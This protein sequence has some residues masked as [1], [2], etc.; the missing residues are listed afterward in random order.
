MRVED[1]IT[2]G[3]P[4]HPSLTIVNK[5]TASSSCWVANRTCPS[6]NDNATSVSYL[7]IQLTRSLGVGDP[8]MK[9]G[10]YKLNFRKP[11]GASTRAQCR[12]L[13]HPLWKYNWISGA[14]NEREYSESDFDRLKVESEYFSLGDIFCFFYY[15]YYI[16]E[17]AVQDG[18]LY[19]REWNFLEWDISRCIWLNSPCLA[20]RF[21]S[22]SWRQIITFISDLKIKYR[23]TLTVETWTRTPCPG[24][25]HLTER[26]PWF[27]QE[28][29]ARA[30][31]IFC[32]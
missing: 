15:A 32:Q 23:G 22:H 6:L 12:T 20:S 31:C 7:Y 3:H 16:V 29:L 25:R 30:V 26:R 2:R 28:N 17:G 18:L 13:N 11:Q 8:V 10:N 24:S 4:N 21:K 1:W 19:A 5:T 9:T 14:F 27:V